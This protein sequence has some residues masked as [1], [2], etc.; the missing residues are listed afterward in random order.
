VIFSG[1]QQF[2]RSVA[3][4][5]ELGVNRS[6]LAVSRIISVLMALHGTSKRYITERLRREGQ[7]ELLAAVEAGTITAF[8]AAAQLNWIKRPA[9]PDRYSHQAK[10]RR[11]RL[12]TVLGEL[13][14]GQKMELIYGP[15]PATGSYF[16]S[17]EALQAAW[18]Q[19]R[20]ELLA[21]SN[22]GRRPAIWWELEARALGLKWPGYFNEQSYLYNKAGVLTAE[23]RATLERE[24]K[25]DFE[26]AQADDFLV[27]DGSGELLK[28][29]C[30]RAAHYAWADIPTALVKRWAAAARRRRARAQGAA[31]GAPETALS[32]ASSAEGEGRMHELQ[33]DANTTA[34]ALK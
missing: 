13:S 22:P 17:R 34:A 12:Q 18:T 28:G 27:N 24:W 6:A 5:L 21:R 9:P 10:K 31:S 32:V 23:E 19:M 4:S 1:A 20:D 8:T 15:S 11:H 16:D 33:P 26:T 2:R 7:T 3:Q 14:A 30:A 25:A 29:D